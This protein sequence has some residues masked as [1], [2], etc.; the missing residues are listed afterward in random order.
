M[1]CGTSVDVSEFEKPKEYL[2]KP[3]EIIDELSIKKLIKNKQSVI[4]TEI[5]PS[6]VSFTFK[7][8]SEH[9][10]E[11]IKYYSNI[12][13]HYM[14][15]EIIK[16]SGFGGDGIVFKCK[17]LSTLGVSTLGVSTLGTETSLNTLGSPTTE[18][19]SP[20]AFSEEMIESEFSKKTFEEYP[21]ATNKIVAIK[22]GN[23]L[24]SGEKY[25]IEETKN[26]KFTVNVYYSK[27]RTFS[28]QDRIKINEIMEV[29]SG[30]IH[31]HI[32]ISEY[33]YTSLKKYIVFLKRKHPNL[34][35]N[36]YITKRICFQILK[37]IS[38]WHE[39]RIYHVDIKPDN[40][41]MDKGFNIKVADFGSSLNYK[42]K[43]KKFSSIRTTKYYIAPEVILFPNF[44][45]TENHLLKIDSWSVGCTI[46]ELITG[47]VLFKK[48]E[49]VEMMYEIISSVGFMSDVNMRKLMLK[50]KGCDL[51]ASDFDSF[52]VLNNYIN[53]YKKEKFTDNNEVLKKK[54]K[55]EIKFDSIISI[56]NNLLIFDP[57][58]RMSVTEILK[59][60]WF[61]N[62][63]E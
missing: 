10:T 19:K 6:I 9:R 23:K 27:I 63:D 57:D 50:M 18:L 54:L 61:T 15:F 41:L 3:L 52:E 56:I 42:I 39:K 21:I 2:E 24:T 46:Y 35:T 22:F 45:I 1:G 30:E 33:I 59:N 7:E 32:M 44:I 55:L 62:M 48:K 14:P 36:L 53:F 34:L 49:M 20:I 58:K 51:I 43:N 16:M 4:G 17:R 29:I 5:F 47:N 60:K 28:F 13:K 11:V 12:I 26:M 38:E 25:A 37:G 31:T 40:L 8:I